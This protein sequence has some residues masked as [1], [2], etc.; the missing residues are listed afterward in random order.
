MYDKKQ[1]EV[2]GGNYV[3]ANVIKS[4]IEEAKNY[5][6]NEKKESFKQKQNKEVENVIIEQEKI[7]TDFNN[8]W[9]KVF[10]EF[11]TK[12]NLA[13]EK[14]DKK[15]VEE[16]KQLNDS[17][18]KNATN[19]KFSSYY[20][21]MVD[22][23]MKLVSKEKYL[24]AQKIRERVLKVKEIEIQKYLKDQ[25]VK[26][27]TQVSM[28]NKL[29][30][31][32]LK[33]LKKKIEEERVNLERD[34][35]KELHLIDFNF[36]SKKIEVEVKQRHDKKEFDVNIKE[37]AL[38]MERNL[39]Q[40]GLNSSTANQSFSYGNYYGSNN[41]KNTNNVNNSTYTQNKSF[42]NANNVSQV[43]LNS[44]ANKK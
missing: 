38:A 27:N 40:S 37:E 22:M 31:N 13:I 36:K 7:M 16:I 21:K 1:K 28:L 20:N 15:N 39:N 44:S 2:A 17:I 42:N 24:D 19:I 8:K 23:E 32:E 12:S 29:H 4:K 34:R 25:V 41:T 14:L 10:S 30:E 5:F 6:T 35:V 3:E 11:E 43:D 9:K 33:N 26:F 18:D